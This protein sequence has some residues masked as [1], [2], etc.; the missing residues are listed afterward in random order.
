MWLLDTTT[1]TLHLEQD[2]A[3][4]TYAILSHVWDQP[5]VR[6]RLS[7]KVRS[8]CD[9]AR[10]QGFKYAWIDTCCIDKSSS[11]EL[12]EAITSMFDWYSI[13]AVCYVFLADVPE[14]ENPAARWSQFGE[15]R[16]FE[17]GWTLQEL[18]VPQRN[19]FLSKNWRPIGTKKSLSK[20]IET[21]TGI[22]EDILVHRRPLHT[23]SVARRM[24]W[25]QFRQTTR[26]ED[27]AYC[28][29]GI[30]GVRIPAIYGEGRHAF[31]RLQE[32]I[33]KSIPDQSLFAWGD[34]LPFNHVGPEGIRLPRVRQVPL[35]EL[36]AS[37]GAYLLASCP[38]DFDGKCKDF[39]PVSLAAL[40][41]ML[42]IPPLET[43]THVPTSHG[44]RVT[45]PIFT[46]RLPSTKT[47]W[48]N[49]ELGLLACQDSY[50]RLAALILSAKD[51]TSGT[52]LVSGYKY[53][54]MSSHILNDVDE[55]LLEL[56]PVVYVAMPYSARCSPLYPRIIL[57]QPALI[58]RTI[59]RHSGPLTYHNICI[60]HQRLPAG[61]A[62][63]NLAMGPL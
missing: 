37:E 60:T 8:C 24:S 57:L 26:V 13:A 44:V 22:D 41:S 43:P 18:L 58:A 33:M 48:I 32:E 38:L 3:R 25:A 17:R 20:T 12:S 34:V 19:V 9:Y 54:G 28:L 59:A 14:T 62:R 36:R 52:Y 6:E 1:Y 56:A 47:G 29:M 45:L 51:T 53:V 5:L 31:V 10:S 15:S 42:G 35:D 27:E 40:S 2:P 55:D 23:V 49:V 11:A 50:G 61:S 21:I 39:K 4:V 46:L 7:P 63:P 16:W 30:F